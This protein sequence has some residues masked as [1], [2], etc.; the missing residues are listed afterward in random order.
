MLNILSQTT[1]LWVKTI[2]VQVINAVIS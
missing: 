1:E 2:H